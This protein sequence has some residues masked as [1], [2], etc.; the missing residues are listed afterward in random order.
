[1]SQNDFQRFINSDGFHSGLLKQEQQERKI[2]NEY[3]IMYKVEYDDFIRKLSHVILDVVPEID[4]RD[5]EHQEVHYYIGGN[6][7]L[8]GFYKL[9]R[10]AKK[11]YTLGMDGLWYESPI[12]EIGK[13]YPVTENTLR[14]F[15]I[16]IFHEYHMN[17]EEA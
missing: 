11:K 2:Q 3:D 15:A 12:Y 17:E 4:I 16:D 1:M 10:N 8:K 7:Y 9:Y 5:I 14:T 6:R 13:G